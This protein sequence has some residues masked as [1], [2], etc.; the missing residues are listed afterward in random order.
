MAL[1]D[2]WEL[3]QQLVNGG[4]SNAQAA[5]TKFAESAAPRSAGA[6]AMSHKVISLAHSDGLVKLG[7]VGLLS[8]LGFLSKFVGIFGWLG[9]KSIW[10]LSP[11]TLIDK[12]WQRPSVAATQKHD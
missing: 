6:I 12:M 5:I 4:H 10:N 3:A 2:A 9:F 7:F 1:Q 8:L 11:R